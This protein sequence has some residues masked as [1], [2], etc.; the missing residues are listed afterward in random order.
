MKDKEYLK[1]LEKTSIEM[2]NDYLYYGYGLK[3]WIEQDYNITKELGIKRIKELFDQQI[4]KIGS[5]I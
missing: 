3:T 1:Q 4:K 2:I 5:E